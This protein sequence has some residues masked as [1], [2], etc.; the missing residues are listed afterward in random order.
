MMFTHKSIVN[1]KLIQILSRIS[2]KCNYYNKII[3][4]AP[5]LQI[6]VKR[7]DRNKIIRVTLPKFDLRFYTK[8]NNRDKIIYNTQ[9]I[10]R[11]QTCS[12]HNNTHTKSYY[13]AIN[14]YDQK[15]FE[16]AEKKFVEVLKPVMS[17]ANA[18]NVDP[19][20][21]FRLKNKLLDSMYH[22]GLIYQHNSQSY[23]NNYAKAVSI[24]Q[25]CAMFAEKYGIDIFDNKFFI[26]E[27]CE[28]E[29]HF[30]QSIGINNGWTQT[31]KER[32]PAF[33][34]GWAQALS[35]RNHE[36]K[37]KLSAFRYKIKKKIENNDIMIHQN[38]S[39]RAKQVEIIY[40][41][42]ANFFVNDNRSGFIQK[43]FNDCHVQLGGPS[44]EVE[45]AIFALGSFSN[46]TA[47]PWSDLEFGILIN[48]D[49]L[50]YVQYFRNLTQLFHIKII[51]LSESQL[52][53]IGIESFNDFK[54]ANDDDDWF[55]DD[56][57]P[58][59]FSLDGA[60]WHA[61]KTPL[62]R[63]NYK[64]KII[65]KNES[66]VIID[67]PDFEL[68]LTPNDALEFQR[69]T[70]DWSNTDPHLVQSLRSILLIDG[71]QGLVDKYRSD[72]KNAVNID[73]VR[74]RTVKIL[75]KDIS[76][77][78]LN[79]VPHLMNNIVVDVK[80]DIY[81]LVDRIINAFSNYYD[82]VA[83]CGQKYINS[84]QILDELQNMQIISQI[85]A[86]HLKEALSI[87]TELR[88]RTYINNISNHCE[89]NHCEHNHCVRNP[90]KELIICGPYIDIIRHFYQV[91]LRVQELCTT[92]SLAEQAL[93]ND[94]LYV[95][96][97]YTVDLINK[98]L[99]INHE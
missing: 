75:Q 94:P 31:L 80:K 91:M 77:F 62:G 83:Q 39:S 89:Y 63:K 13:S 30:L 20:N 53:W 67:K 29:K 16:L 2:T 24:Y 47:T 14:Y 46:G 57:M 68:I 36:Y 44:K 74:K 72:M 70:S 66:Q 93:H 3:T 90:D 10:D 9:K 52:R 19:N 48:S 35:E 69:S 33:K 15:N 7:T 78:R 95:D 88:L 73:V 6:H 21:I 71:S 55:W 85:G 59:G 34:N 45:Y 41:E 96:D 25:Y 18:K 11:H 12:T 5:K 38:I 64:A 4:N 28:I 22:M 43:L 51:N 76:K 27:A 79:L 37:N 8:C 58:Y 98:R 92:K 82:I 65:L 81:R 60:Q 50:H 56:V 23:S 26:N 42:I 86:T 40:T 17:K 32:E 49:D 1:F 99:G 84:W 87:A 97:D 54:T 61:C